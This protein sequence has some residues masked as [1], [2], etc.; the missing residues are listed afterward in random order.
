LLLET[1]IYI[2]LSLRQINQI[3]IFVSP[4]RTTLE[5]SFVLHTMIYRV[6]NI[7]V[8][9][10]LE[11]IAS[12]EGFILK[13]NCTRNTLKHLSKCW[14]LIRIGFYDVRKSSYI[15]SHDHNVRNCGTV[16]KKVTILWNDDVCYAL[17]QHT[18]LDLYCTIMSLTQ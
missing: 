10:T 14:Y 3:N 11:Y 6:R 8:V 17:Y 7:Q 15:P 2:Y 13:S 4:H 9:R 5:K 1:S 18:E 16:K 12:V